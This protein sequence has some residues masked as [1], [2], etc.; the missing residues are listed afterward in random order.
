MIISDDDFWNRFKPIDEDNGP[1]DEIPSGT[2]PACVWT[3]VDTE[4]GD[5]IISGIHFVNRFAF[6]ICRVPVPAGEDYEVM[7]EQGSDQEA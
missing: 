7:V 5:S 6:W 3:C 2:D 4:I 1:I